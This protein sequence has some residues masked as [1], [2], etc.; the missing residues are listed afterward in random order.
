M[1]ARFIPGLELAGA[2]FAEVVR[3]LLAEAFPQLPYAAALLGPGSEV[4]GYDSVRSTD[5]DWGPRLQIFLADSD[6]HR[7]AAGITA[8]LASRLPARFR[9]HPTAF[10][11]T[12]EPD[13][14]ARYRVTVT[15]LGAWLTGQLGFDPRQRV[16]VADWLAAP[17]QRLAELTAGAVFHDGPG[18]LSQARARLAW[19]PHDVWL[20]VLASQWQRIAQEEAFPGRCAEAGD[21]LGSAIV[22]ARLARDLMRLC[23]LMRHR[24]PPYSKWLGTAFA[25]LPEAAAVT[26]QLTAAVAAT[27]WP[28]R[29]QHLGQAFETSAAMHNELGITRPLDTRT[30]GYFDRPYRVLDAGRFTAALREA[31]TDPLIQQLP[32]VGAVDQF[33]DNTDALRDTRFLRAVIAVAKPDG[34]SWPAP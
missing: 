11:S 1:S 6:S 17:T 2:F 7:R 12:G 22:T 23:L 8:M 15:D 16:T 13:G 18:G 4:L 3:P 31:I 9:G 19:Y 21:E 25:Q 5:H 28:A 30:R 26:P 14:L 29:Q 24:Y 20:Y 27:S 32:A 34:Q 10:P 33:I